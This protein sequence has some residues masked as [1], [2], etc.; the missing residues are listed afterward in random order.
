VSFD[1]QFLLTRAS[2]LE[3]NGDASFRIRASLSDPQA[4]ISRIRDQLP[5]AAHAPRGGAAPRELQSAYE[6]SFDIS[7][8]YSFSA[9]F[10]NVV[11]PRF[12]R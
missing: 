1:S 4:G 6:V 8:T 7:F 9:L 12:G 2:R 3:L 5:S 10:N 11:N